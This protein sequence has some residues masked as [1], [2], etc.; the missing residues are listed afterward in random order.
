MA[1]ET[2]NIHQ[3]ILAVMAAVPYVQKDA[4]VEAGGGRS[5]K[6]VTHDA[7][8]AKLR[9]PMIE[10]GIVL[11]VSQTAEHAIEGQTK[12]GGAKIRY[13]AWYDVTLY[14]ADQPD[15][16]VTYRVHAHAEDGGD[17]APGKAMSYATKTVL[18]KAFALETGESDESRYKPDEPMIPE[19][20]PKERMQ[21]AMEQPHV[22]EAVDEIKASLSNGDM[23]TAAAAWWDKLDDDDKKAVWLAPTKGGI[24]TVDE[25]ET[26]KSAE[27]RQAYYGAAATS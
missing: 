20:T 24:F 23:A 5:Y 19:P 11:S 9:A 16:C 3:R 25:R 18:L 13:E 2:K 22:H 26:I 21:A 8:V 14:N 1:T 4:T 27:F 15:D 17:K 12:S 6:G 10:H 7:V